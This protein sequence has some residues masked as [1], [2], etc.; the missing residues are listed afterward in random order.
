MKIPPTNRSK[1]LKEYIIEIFRRNWTGAEVR[2][3]GISFSKLT[4]TEAIQLDLFNEADTPINDHKLDL[5]IDAIRKKYGFTS[6]VHA[7]SLMEGGTA[8]SRALNCSKLN[9]GQNI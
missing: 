7:N 6:I 8:I 4:Y 9:E 5:L 2:R 3:V 1:L